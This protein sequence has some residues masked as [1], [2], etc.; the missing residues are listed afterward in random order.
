[1]FTEQ[2]T[3]SPKSPD[4]VIHEFLSGFNTVLFFLNIILGF[5]TFQMY[6]NVITVWRDLYLLSTT[7]KRFSKEKGCEEGKN[8]CEDDCED[9]CEDSCEENEDTTANEEVMESSSGESST[10]EP[11][12]TY[13]S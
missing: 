10:D 2:R 4:V 9:A 6:E 3:M 13:F 12:I 1:M 7:V 8:D 11:D 5:F